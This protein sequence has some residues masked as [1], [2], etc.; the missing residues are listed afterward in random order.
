MMTARISAA[1]TFIL[2]VTF[3]CTSAAS[4]DQDHKSFLK[5]LST[6]FHNYSSIS[7]L[8]YTPSNSSY[9][10]VLL[11]PIWN[12]RFTSDSTP[13]PRVIITPEH[14]SQIPPIIYCAKKNGVEIRTRSGGHDFEALSSVSKVSFVIIDL[15]KLSQVTVD[16]AAK[17]A[18]V[19]GGATL[20][21]LYY[22]IAEKS[23]TL[24]FPG[25]MCATV[26]VG[27]HIS[28][29]G[30]GTLFRK[31]GMAADHVIDARIVD[32]NGKILNRKSM[33]EDLFWAIR[34]GGGASFGVIVAWKLQLV[35]VPEIVTV[36]I[37]QRTME[38]NLTRLIHRWQYV[39]P[40]LDKDITL[41]INAVVNSS[42]DGRYIT[43]DASFFGV[44]VGRVD[45]L[46]A[47]MQQNFPELGMVREDCTEMSW[48]QSALFMDGHPIDTP[49]A[50]LSRVSR[51]KSYMKRRTD[52]VQRPIPRRVIAGLTRLYNEPVAKLNT[53]SF[54]PYGGIMAEIPASS[55]PYPH[56]AGNMYHVFYTA[57]WQESSSRNPARYMNWLTRAYNYMTPYVSK[58]PRGAYLNY[59]DLD[60]G[61]N[62]V[63][64]ETSVAQ[65]SIWGV[66]YFKN[67]FD[68]LV[69]VKTK[70]DRNNFFRNEHSIPPLRKK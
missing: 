42:Q 54:V 38:Q 1:V 14:E 9:S 26:G 66:R 67:N 58:N 61:V 50:L 34:G 23:K 8:I 12:L 35:D 13:K 55:I 24:A 36:F 48:I 29:G 3:S 16:A 20:G 27:G 28:G 31:Y 19:E 68:R 11:F 69:R 64:G 52:Y 57:Y 18:W 53:L 44:F 10:S 37:I 43:L 60:L 41:M 45:K 4:T 32:V 5:C 49:E 15:V 25:G 46:M 40:R 2:L 17:T 59:R 6:K 63:K 70:V 33:G 22:R 21:S 65:A 62:N 30:S 56:R 51:N 39:A 7:N 47:L